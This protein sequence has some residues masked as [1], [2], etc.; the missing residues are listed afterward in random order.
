MNTTGDKS[1]ARLISAAPDLL[2]ACNAVLDFAQY[3]DRAG[4]DGGCA[5]IV[6]KLEWA[7]AKATGPQ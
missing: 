6:R 1:N 2:A 5:D 3:A 4:F 7:I